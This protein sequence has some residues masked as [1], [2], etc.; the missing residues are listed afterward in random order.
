MKKAASALSTLGGV[1]NGIAKFKGQWRLTCKVCGW[2][3]THTSGYHTRWAADPNNF[4]LPATHAY[5]L[6][7]GK[8]PP[9]GHVPDTQPAAAPASAS[10]SIGSAQSLLSTRM[11]PLIA[12]Y[13]TNSEDGQF[14]SFLADFERALN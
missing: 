1:E 5:W 9:A 11:G 2:N 10:G 13:K 4:S 8:T 3:K 12:Q 7:T 14:S 6:K